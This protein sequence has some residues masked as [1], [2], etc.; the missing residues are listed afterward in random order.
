VPSAKHGS[1]ADVAAAGVGASA[2]MTEPVGMTAN[3]DGTAAVS[4]PSGGEASGGSTVH[5]PDVFAA[6]EVIARARAP[7]REGRRRSGGTPA[8]AQSRAACWAFSAR[9]AA[10]ARLSPDAAAAAVFVLAFFLVTAAC[11]WNG[12]SGSGKRLPR[13]GKEEADVKPS[14]TPANPGAPQSF[15]KKSRRRRRLS[16]GV[17]A[18]TA[19][20]STCP[21]PPQRY[22]PM[23]RCC[24]Q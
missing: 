23:P 13:G 18:L 24:A 10:A 14:P 17:A 9:A 6:V 11:A 16:G 1:G 19:P 22:P 4:G 8:A 15:M 2:K 3:G 12:L 20:Q 5:A 7:W 21:L